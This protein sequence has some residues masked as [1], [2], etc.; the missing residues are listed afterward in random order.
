METEPKPT[1]KK[2][3]LLRAKA[4]KIES[5]NAKL[6]AKAEAFKAKLAAGYVVEIAEHKFD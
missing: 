2:I 3:G 5:D 4:L 6:A 1:K